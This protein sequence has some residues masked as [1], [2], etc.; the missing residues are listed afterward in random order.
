[1]FYDLLVGVLAETRRKYG[2]F[3]DSTPNLTTSAYTGATAL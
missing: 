3:I 1:M 2:I